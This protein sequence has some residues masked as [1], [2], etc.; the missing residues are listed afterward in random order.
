MTHNTRTLSF[1]LVLVLCLSL[2][3]VTVS[4]ADGRTFIAT[5]LLATEEPLAQ[6]PRTFEAWVFFP[7]TMNI[8]TR[9]GVILGSYR[10]KGRDLFSFEIYS[11]GSPRIYYVDGQ[12]SHRSVTFSSVNLYNGAWTHVAITQDPGTNTV[13]CYI[14]GNLK[15]T[16]PLSITDFTPAE[17]SV[18]GGDLRD[19]N[20]QYFK[21]Q[22]RSVALFTEPRNE[23]QIKADMVRVPIGGAL[24]SWEIAAGATTVADLSPNGYTISPTADGRT[25]YAG[26]RIT[27]VKNLSVT[28]NTFETR[29]YFPSSMDT[30]T[31][32]GVILGNYKDGG[33][34]L[35]S[36]EIFSKGN[37]RLYY[38]DGKGAVTDLKFTS[39]NVYT[40]KW[41]HLAVVRDVTAGKA[42]CYVDGVLKQ[43][44]S[45]SVGDILPSSPMVVGGDPRTDNVRFFRGQMQSVT[46]YSDART[47]AE[48]KTDMNQF[49]NGDPIAAWDVSSYGVRYY[50]WSGNGYHLNRS[51]I[52]LSFLRNERLEANK[53]LT[54]MPNTLEAWLC[55][56][57]D[58]PT[59]SRGGVIVGNYPQSNKNVLNFEIH[60]NGNPRMYYLDKE[61]TV[62]EARFTTVNVYTGNWIHLTLVRDVSAGKAHCYVNGVLKESLPL[63]VGNFIP[64]GRMTVGGDHRSDNA[65]YFKGRIRSVELF[66]DART[67]SEITADMKQIPSGDP[68][69]AWDLNTESHSYPDLSGKACHLNRNSSWFTEKDTVSDY[70]YT[71]AVLGDTQKV[72][73]YDSVNGTKNLKKV[74]SWILSQEDAMNIQYVMGLGDIT[75][76]NTAAEWELA[77]EA[78]HQLNG[79]IPYSLVR[80]NHDGSAALNK[81]FNDPAVSPY[82]TTYEGTYDGSMDNSWR[83]ITVGENRIPY[84]I[85][86]LDYGPNDSVLAWAD[87]VVSSHPHHNVIITTHCYLFRDGTTLDSGDVCPP[88]SSGS[89]KNNGDHMWE[90]FVKKHEN[91]ILVL[92]GHDPCSNI[93]M[94]QDPGVHGNT[95]TQMLID[96]QG[97]DAS[98]L[99]GAVALFH[100][101]ADGR[102]VS[103]EYY[104]PLQEAWF[105]TSNQ[106]TME[107]DGVDPI[108]DRSI[109]LSHSL[110]LV[111]DISMNYVISAEAL[112]QYDSFYLECTIPTYEGN[113][114]TGSVTKEIRPVLNGTRYYFALEG[115]TALQMND[116]IEA[117]LC[118][119]RNG[120]SYVSLSDRY[121]IATYAYNQLNKTGISDALKQVCADLLQYGAAAQSWKGYRTDALPTASMT[122]THRAYLTDLA[123]VSFGNHKN[124]LNDLVDPTVTWGG[125]S[126]SLENRIVIRF[127]LNL[128]A[129]T[130]DPSAL[131]LRISY[132]GTDG[133]IRTAELKNAVPYHASMGL[134]AFDFD[135][136][137]AS[138]IRTVVSAAV[139]EGNTR[140]SQTGQ[141]SI[142]TYGNNK[143]GVLLDLCR[144]MVAYGD[145]A[146]AFF[147]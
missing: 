95:V 36:F 18:L 70:D 108:L 137:N 48:I 83:T 113:T 52:G 15:E 11:G 147:G 141:Y 140:I 106:F 33:R 32:G 58:M 44:L 144:A 10:D 121:S 75:D 20:K 39:V 86:T 146:A 82:S 54:A 72:S 111:S 30:A 102:K 17:V 107:L 63:S 143:T 61:G 116:I 103:V 85:M 35:I 97:V 23:V 14:N 139:Y 50:D 64:V 115:L 5:E 43:S 7:N 118:M 112:S 89:D 8:S 62:K 28:P 4:A 80:G 53:A 56:P 125:K 40:G 87:K 66:A 24:A 96:P 21:G 51:T 3:P 99:T 71:F 59:S 105:M 27:S 74:Y 117:R 67:Q 101:S 122:S 81:Y 84:L 135:G 78:V 26:E 120:E 142:D 29:I 46:L 68:I 90:K 130:G 104:S 123:T 12:G 76:R 127:L 6:L 94:R 13:S 31:R 110:N 77:R 133:S 34:N 119:E 47:Q 132:I 93:V 1:L 16:L 65:Q 98:T 136:L 134:Y 73:Y 126:L 55:F 79:Q 92:S 60:T 114:L 49:D 109:Q 42:H 88:T 138:E 25:F 91:I 2:L 45:L 22:L 100:F 131:S 145:S 57:A 9:G 129:Y 69:A 41:L 38:V 19:G 124:T 128:S 37:P